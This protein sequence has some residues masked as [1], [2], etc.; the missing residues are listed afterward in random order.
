MVMVMV[1]VTWWPSPLSCHWS[2]GRQQ[3]VTDTT[4]AEMII[5]IIVD[6]R[7]GENFK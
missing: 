5:I 7:D 6:H 3:A 1:I 2:D 4:E